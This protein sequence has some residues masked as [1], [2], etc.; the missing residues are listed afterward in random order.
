MLRRSLFVPLLVVV[1]V[2]SQRGFAQDRSD[3][4]S[5]LERSGRVYLGVGLSPRRFDLQIV[6]VVAGSPA[7]RAGLKAGDRLVSVDGVKVTDA[8]DFVQRIKAKTPGDQ[9]KVEAL[10]GEERLLVEVTLGTTDSI[11]P[12]IEPR[13]GAAGRAFLGVG[14]GE[15]PV[16]LAVHLGLDPGAGVLVGDVRPGSA[17]ETAGIVTHDVIV[18]I[19]RNLVEGRRGLVDLIGRRRPGD[20]VFLDIIHRGEPATKK[21]VLGERM[22]PPRSPRPRAW[23]RGRLKIGDDFN[24]EIPWG[25]DEWRNSLPG[26]LRERLEDGRFDET[27]RKHLEEAF[28]DFDF[29][30][31]SRARSVVRVIEG[32]LDITVKSDDGERL[33]TVKKGS[34]TIAKDLP[35]EKLDTL[36]ADV[37]EAV[38]ELIEQHK[39]ELIEP[40][41]SGVDEVE[42]LDRVKI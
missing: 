1:G 8:L 17:A 21:V 30:S 10:R 36:P 41:S 23:W 16:L 22:V 3:S 20:E 4:S 42:G 13:D 14:Y 40:P 28:K 11:L 31:S 35:Y 5:G 6:Q 37:L 19:D 26:D 33:V 29:R 7:E 38:R 34:D 12:R 15:V 18:K 2:A 25:I 27:I 24:Y 9:L 32:D 39:V